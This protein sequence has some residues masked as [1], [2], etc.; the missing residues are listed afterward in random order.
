M[1]DRAG[2][3]EHHDGHTFS[4]DTKGHDWL[5]EENEWG[6]PLLAMRCGICGRRWMPSE[7]LAQI[8]RCRG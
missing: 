2:A 7:S 5:R 6:E 4:L 8:G 3:E 1:G